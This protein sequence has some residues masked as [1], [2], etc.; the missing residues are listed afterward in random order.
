MRQDQDHARAFVPGARPLAPGE[1]Y[2]PRL[3]RYV[4]PDNVPVYLTRFA[5][6]F[7]IVF[8]AELSVPKPFNLPEQFGSVADGLHVNARD[9]ATRTWRFQRFAPAWA[10]RLG[11]DLTG[12]SVLHPRY[13]P[14][15]TRLH[16]MLEEAVERET[17]FYAAFHVEGPRGSEEVHRLFIPMSTNGAA[18]AHCLVFTAV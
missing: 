1:V 13:A 10:A 12:E 14:Y 2:L 8:D 15:N 6:K 16:D 18:V 3:S 5:A 7:R 11:Q 9:P 4:L 17:P